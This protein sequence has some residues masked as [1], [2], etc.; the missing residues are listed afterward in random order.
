M[1]G[2][3]SR[4][5]YDNEYFNEFV[6]QQTNEGNYRINNVYSEN[7]NRCYSLFGPRQNNNNT[8]SEISSYNVSD[9]REIESYL[10][11]LDMPT[12]RSMNYRTLNDK[13]DKLN[14]LLKSKQLNTFNE[15]NNF[16]DINNTRLDN[17]LRDFKS[18]NIDRYEYPIIQ[19]LNYVFNGFSN[20]E[21]V[22]ND[23]NGVNSR[24]R[25]KDSYKL[26]K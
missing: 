10:R 1:S 17:D 23:R 11:N 12:S 5:K 26:N 18:V 14:D 20:T 3:V 21:Q 8:N 13:N 6:N 24:L 4:T 16:L 7:N 19:P 9:R 25:A 2:I 15:C 22:N